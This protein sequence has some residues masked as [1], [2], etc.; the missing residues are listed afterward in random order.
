MKNWILM[1]TAIALAACT[2][3]NYDSGDGKYSYMRADFVDAHFAAEKVAD[4]V[5]TDDGERIAFSEPFEVSWGS[6]ADT[7]YRALLY[8]DC[9]PDNYKP[10]SLKYVYVLWPKEGASIKNPAFDPVEF[11]SAWLSKCQRTDLSTILSEGRQEEKITYY[12]NVSFLVKTGQPDDEKARQTIG[13]MGDETSDGSFRLTL[14]HDQ[15]AIPEYYSNRAYVSIP[16]TDSQL[17]KPLS[18]IINTYDGLVEKE[19]SL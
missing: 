13:I 16:L 12:L 19:F 17:A 15:G 6:K 10:I 14:L 1:L 8:Y 3:E 18:L 7:L 9:Q 5:L 2:S 11:E 4:Y